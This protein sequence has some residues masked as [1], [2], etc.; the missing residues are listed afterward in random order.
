M[1]QTMLLLLLLLLFIIIVVGS[2]NMQHYRDSR[3]PFSFSSFRENVIAYG[4][5][6]GPSLLFKRA[7]LLVHAVH[8]FP[9][10]SVRIYVFM[11]CNVHVNT[12][13]GMACYFYVN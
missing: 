9:H 10:A 2:T 7:N 12:Q 3:W 13:R 11:L 4:Y 8:R 6:T 1:Q 5:N